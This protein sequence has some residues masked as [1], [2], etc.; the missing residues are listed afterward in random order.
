[1]ARENLRGA[2]YGRNVT[3]IYGDGS[4]GYPDFGAL[5]RDFRG[6]GRGRRFPRPCSTNCA[7]PAGW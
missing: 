4:L 7:T 1:M 5:R 6:R 2:G 3:V